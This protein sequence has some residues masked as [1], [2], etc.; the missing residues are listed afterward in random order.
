[1]EKTEWI[2]LSFGSKQGKVLIPHSLYMPKLMSWIQT[3]F[4]LSEMKKKRKKKRERERHFNNL[5][6]LEKQ[7]FH[8]LITQK[9]TEWIFSVINRGREPG[10][11]LG[12]RF[13]NGKF[14]F[15]GGT[16]GDP[17]NAGGAE[18]E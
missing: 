9:L 3:S 8:S 6:K 14:Q 16:L 5:L 7:I 1:M 15:K 18:K 10:G 4:E 17:R 2:F 11:T 13:K 12:E